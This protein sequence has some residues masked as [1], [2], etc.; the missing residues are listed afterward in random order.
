MIEIP[1]TFDAHMVESVMC[2]FAS[3][4]EPRSRL[5]EVPKT[6]HMKGSTIANGWERKQGSQSAVPST[7][8]KTEDLDSSLSFTRRSFPS[9]SS[10]SLPEHFNF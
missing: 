7:G 4:R 10:K 6:Q 1:M 5:G 9:A 2:A 3:H 8:A